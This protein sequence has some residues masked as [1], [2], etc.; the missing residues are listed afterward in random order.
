MKNNRD[1][2]AFVIGIFTCIITILSLAVAI[3]ALADKKKKKE[4]KELEDYLDVSIN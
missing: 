4:E 3:F 1:S 2:L